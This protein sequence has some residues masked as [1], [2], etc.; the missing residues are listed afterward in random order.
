MIPLAGVDRRPLARAVNELLA[1]E[2]PEVEMILD[3]DGAGFEAIWLCGAGAEAAQWVS[4]IRSRYPDALVVVTGR[5]L[6]AAQRD[7]VAA[8]ADRVLRWPSSVLELREAFCS[9]PLER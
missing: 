4:E 9:V 3:D 1:T 5:Q 2:L 6:Q 7:L 8:G